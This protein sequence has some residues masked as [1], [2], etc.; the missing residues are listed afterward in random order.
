M[1]CG[2]SHAVPS[3]LNSPEKADSGSLNIRLSS[4]TFNV[5]NGPADTRD[6]SVDR[7]GARGDAETKHQSGPTASEDVPTHSA[8]EG[9]TILELRRRS[10]IRAIGKLPSISATPG[11][12]RMPDVNLSSSDTKEDKPLNELRPSF[13]SAKP[14]ARSASPPS[15]VT[16]ND[17]LLENIVYHVE[18]QI[19]LSE[20]PAGSTYTADRL[21]RDT[22]SFD[23]A[24]GVVMEW[25]P[26]LIHSRNY[27]HRCR[28]DILTAARRVGHAREILQLPR[29]HIILVYNPVSG[30][31]KSKL[32]VDHVVVYC[33]GH[34]H[35]LTVVQ[36]AVRVVD[37]WW[38]RSSSIRIVLWE[39]GCYL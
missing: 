33:G 10:S 38:L 21:N 19:L 18:Q 22:L 15:K 35:F 11:Q 7:G 27:L 31:G 26:S 23:A 1:G 2:A 30:G 25:P 17:Q 6:R 24:T 28:A 16:T 4:R 13:D 20:D 39:V 32:M 3:S 5:D 29:R 37:T 36:L 34:C 9:T 8:A 12:I 14:R